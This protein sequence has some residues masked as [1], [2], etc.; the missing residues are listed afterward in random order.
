MSGPGDHG[1]GA[2][3]HGASDGA[4][5]GGD[6]VNYTKVIGVGV[7]SLALFAVSI[8]VAAVIYHGAVNEAE[9][10]A[11]RAR[12]PDTH[13]AEIG[14]VDQV[15]FAS[16]NRLHAWRAD[17]RRELEGYSWVDKSRGVVRIPV[18]TAMDKV[19]AGALPAG[20]PR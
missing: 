4:S 16:D 17:R 1:H 20:A 3:S 5:G 11:G 12:V 18:E 10:R 14:I 15:P 9:S 2:R 6:D 19:A 13:R 7:G 8:W